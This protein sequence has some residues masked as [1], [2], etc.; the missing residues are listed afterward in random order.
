MALSVVLLLTFGASDE[1]PFTC[2]VRQVT[3]GPS[4]HFYGYIGHVGNTPWN[5]GGRYMVMLRTTF[6]DHLPAPNEAADV[7]LLDTHNGYAVEKVE[8]SRAWNPQQGTMLYWNPEKPETQFFFNDRDGK[9]NQVF[10]VLYDI[11]QRKRIREY[12][13]DGVS[14]GNSGVAQQGGFFL[15]INYGRLARLRPV[16]GYPEAYDWTVGVES[17]TDDGIFKIDVAT[18]EKSLLVSYAQMAERLPRVDAG[19]ELFINHSLV[20]REDDQ[21]YFFARGAWKWFDRSS[22]R[23]HRIDTPFSI[24]I[25][26]SGL[27]MHDQHIGGHP[28]WAPGGRL[29]GREEDRQVIYDVATQHVV[30][31]IGNAEILPQPGGD[32]ALSPDEQWIVNGYKNKKAR[33]NRYTVVNV[34]TGAYFALPPMDIG[35]WLS[36]DLRIDG[37]PCWRRDGRAIAVPGLGKDN[38]RQ[39]FVFELRSESQEQ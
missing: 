14:I 38:T 1:A 27:R 37:A 25:D 26:G 7:V 34:E 36:G 39:T 15:G 28:E 11:E 17:P 31:R 3:Q 5:A 10:C 13:F 2:D 30:G 6:Q 8:E 16:T 35:P 19:T 4:H 18:G 23:P 20:S 24:R 32:V 12:R 22:P 9:T 29:I 33:E 21:V